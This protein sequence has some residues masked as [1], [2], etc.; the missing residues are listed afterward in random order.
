MG[1]AAAMIAEVI[2]IDLNKNQLDDN[3][4][5]PLVAGTAI[6]LVRVYVPILP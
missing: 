1:A 2:E 4:I 6:Y 3:L 5:V